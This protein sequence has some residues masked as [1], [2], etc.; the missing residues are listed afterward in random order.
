[1]LTEGERFV[2]QKF[3]FRRAAQLH[4]GPNCGK[5][6]LRVGPVGWRDSAIIKT[7]QAL[8]SEMWLGRN[9]EWKNMYANLRGKKAVGVWLIN[10]QGRLNHVIQAR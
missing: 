4:Q 1:V 9:R 6:R 3:Q 10:D 2:H 8:S 5:P 7:A